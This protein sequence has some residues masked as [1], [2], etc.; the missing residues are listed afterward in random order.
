MSNLNPHTMFERFGLAALRVVVKKQIIWKSGLQAWVRLD[1]PIHFFG[2]ARHNH[3]QL[4]PVVFHEL[5]QRVHRF[6]SERVFSITF[7]HQG[8]GLIDEEHTTECFVQHFCCFDC[9][10]ADVPRHKASPVRLD[11]MAFRQNTGTGR[12]GR[13]I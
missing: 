9:G 12:F 3:N 10:L 6:L 2:V 4:F 11:T 1:E 7:R 8:I 5:E 13:S